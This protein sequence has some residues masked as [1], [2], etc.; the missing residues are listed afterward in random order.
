MGAAHRVVVVTFT[1]ACASFSL[2]WRLPHTHLLA[3]GLKTEINGFSF[4]GHQLHCF[5]VYTISKICSK[6]HSKYSTV[7]AIWL[8]LDTENLNA[9]K[10]WTS[11][12]NE[13]LLMYFI[14]NNVMI[15]TVIWVDSTI[16]TPYWTY[17][18]FCFSFSFSEEHF[19]TPAITMPSSDVFKESFSNDS[20]LLKQPFRFVQFFLLIY[21]P[22]IP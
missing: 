14:E 10:M 7:T 8:F 16:F 11:N 1:L 17:T 15:Q 18:S 13:Y 5:R 3:M 12:K 20:L 6:G 4:W 22:Y 21:K 19:E 9:S 2:I